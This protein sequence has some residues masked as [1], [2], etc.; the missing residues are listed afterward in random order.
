VTTPPSQA[1][2]SWNGKG[3]AIRKVPLLRAEDGEKESQVGLPE[4][5][6][7]TEAKAMILLLMP[8]EALVVDVA[9]GLDSGSMMLRWIC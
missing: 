2:R 4:D 6:R 1:P 3:E 7:P 9:R 8:D 5:G